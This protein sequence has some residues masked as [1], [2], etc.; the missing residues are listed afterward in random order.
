MIVISHRVRM[1]TRAIDRVIHG[2][3]DTA[4]SPYRFAGPLMILMY[5][6]SFILVGFS[7][8]V[9]RVNRWKSSAS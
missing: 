4:P 2:T 7:T 9:E 8:F 5:I 3:I 1:S 6:S